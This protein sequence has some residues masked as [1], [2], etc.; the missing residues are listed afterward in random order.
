MQFKKKR[1][2]NFEVKEIQL[3]LI[4]VNK[5]NCIGNV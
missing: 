1:V 2:N 4:S 3:Y 5:K